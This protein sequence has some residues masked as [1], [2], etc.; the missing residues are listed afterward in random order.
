M[1]RRAGLTLTEVLVVLVILAIAGALL[2]SRQVTRRGMQRAENAGEMR[3]VVDSARA[4]ARGRSV[5]VRLR[6][7]ADGLWSVEAPAV[8]DPIAAGTMTA[9]PA[10]FDVTV[11]A[12]GAC[13]ATTGSRPREALRAAFDAGKCRFDAAQ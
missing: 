6:V 1:R 10:P 13:R 4:L 5:A 3:A 7:Y 11:D 9:P 12:K 8:A 2:L